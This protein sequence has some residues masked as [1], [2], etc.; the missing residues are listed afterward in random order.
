MGTWLYT[1]FNTSS[2]RNCVSAAAAA[3]GPVASQPASQ[4]ASPPGNQSTVPITSMLNTLH[5]Q[6]QQHPLAHLASRWLSIFGR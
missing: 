3:A 1:W 6:Q 2:S 5:K 4:P